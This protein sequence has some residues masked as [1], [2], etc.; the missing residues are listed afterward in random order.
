ME[1]TSLAWEDWPGVERGSARTRSG[2]LGGRLQ[3]RTHVFAVGRP[4]EMYEASE[5]PGFRAGLM[6]G[7]SRRVVA[8]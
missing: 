8:A 5:G 4:L 1:P 7:H 2:E 3:E 6:P